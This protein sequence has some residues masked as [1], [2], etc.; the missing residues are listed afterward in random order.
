MINRS[1]YVTM[2][3][4]ICCGAGCGNIRYTCA[5]RMVVSIYIKQGWDFNES[6]R[7]NASI[8][9]NLCHNA[10]MLFPSEISKDTFGPTVYRNWGCLR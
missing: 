7:S 5:Q 4:G 9:M 3:V 6:G 8:D 2:T 10:F 1:T